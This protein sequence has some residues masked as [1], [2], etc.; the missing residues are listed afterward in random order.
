MT[1]WTAAEQDKLIEGARQE[2]DLKLS[3]A[4]A[5]TKAYSDDLELWKSDN[6]VSMT[7][8]ALFRKLTS[9]LELQA[10]FTASYQ[11]MIRELSEAR[12]TPLIRRYVELAALC[13]FRWQVAE[14]GYP[15]LTGADRYG[16]E[17]ITF[18]DR[19]L[20][21][22]QWRYMRALEALQRARRL[23]LPVVQFNIADKQQVITLPGT[24]HK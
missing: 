20:A 9:D 19:H 23:P 2:M 11:G 3:R 6:L 12:D 22:V 24:S 8:L 16:T 18:W 7:A 1:D 14:G 21:A 4:H 17:L 13:W 10:T 5:V 15:G